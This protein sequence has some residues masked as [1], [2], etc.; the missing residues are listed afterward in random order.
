MNENEN[1][2][3]V[4]KLTPFTKMVMSIGTLPSSFYASMSY[5]ESMVWLYEY[6]KNQVIPTVNNNAEAVEELQEKYIEFTDTINETVETLEEYMNNYFTNLDVQ[7]E[8]NTKLDEM[9]TDGSLTNLIKAYVN[10]IYE[11]YEDSINNEISEFK[12]SVNNSINSQND[13]ISIINNKVSAV[14][15][16]N[17]IPVSSTSAMTNT[18]RIYVNTTDGYW[19][20]YNGTAWVQGGQYQSTQSTDL[21]EGIN[22]YLHLNNKKYIMDFIVGD[23]NASGI[24]SSTKRIVT[25]TIQCFDEDLYIVNSNLYKYGV[26]TYS[27]ATGAGATWKNWIINEKQSYVIPKGTYFRLLGTWID[28]TNMPDISSPE[29]SPMFTTLKIY[30]YEDYQNAIIKYYKLLDDD[31]LKYFLKFIIGDI[32]S[33]NVLI[34]IAQYRRLVTKDIIKLDYDLTIPAKESAYDSIYLVTYSDSTGSSYTNVGWINE[35]SPYVIPKGTYFRLLI[36]DNNSSSTTPI[37]DIFTSDVFSNL[38]LFKRNNDT[39]ILNKNILFES[40]AHQGYSITSQPLGNCRLSSYIGAKE[41]GFTAGECDIQW[42]SD[43]VPVCCH[44][45]SFSSG[46]NTIVI[47]QHT[48]DEIK[49]LDYYGEKIAS[50]EQVLS[51]CKKL[52][53]KLYIDHVYYSWSSTAW[54]TLLNTIKKYK[55]EDN[56]KFLLLTDSTNIQAANII[57]TWYN[58]AKIALVTEADDLTSVI[59]QA[60]N[61]KTEL[62][63]ISIDCKYTNTT[64]D[65]IASS[66]LLLQNGV[67]IEIWTLDDVSSYKNYLPY[68]SAI[69][70]N[71]ICYNDVYNDLI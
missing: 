70:S 39:I 56:V 54:N 40:V 43:L 52:G 20:Y 4:Q 67:T 3:P 15:D 30:K 26:W 21:V 49:D 36:A 33:G 46:G 17:P 6:L 48:Y 12:S 31:N 55:M 14:V 65:E 47:S 45:A 38:K 2:Q 23:A 57:L 34:D 44:D 58:K 59:T 68:V 1:L 32:S 41:H 61:L 25:N 13:Q 64:T 42:T 50:L 69:T 71:K 35:T 63:E 22:E 62:N 7:E 24:V 5:Y 8:I 18:S 27:D 66:N 37:E 51:T 60:N 11:A 19:Y 10:P 29:E 9:A 28:A 16:N 53:L